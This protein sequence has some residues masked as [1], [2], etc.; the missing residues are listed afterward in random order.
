M[1]AAFADFLRYCRLERRLAEL[2]CSAYERDVRACLASLREQGVDDLATVRRPD[3]RPFLAEEAR[4]RPATVL[5]TK[6]KPSPRR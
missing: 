4:R 2:T 3:L 6:P 1:E 5:L